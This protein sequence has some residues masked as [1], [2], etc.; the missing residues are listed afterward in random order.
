MMGLQAR[1]YR[2]EDSPQDIKLWDQKSWS[3]MCKLCRTGI[4]P[5]PGNYSYGHAMILIACSLES[6]PAGWTRVRQFSDLG[7]I[8]ARVWCSS[9]NDF[10]E[11]GGDVIEAI[12]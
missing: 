3:H 7:K 1:S 11:N 8:R 10:M 12:A 5:D 2:V 9:L 4:G 6:T